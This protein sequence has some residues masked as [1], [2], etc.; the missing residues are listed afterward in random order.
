MA[1]TTVS[2]TSALQSALSAASPGDTIWLNPGA[3]ADWYQDGLDRGGW[4]VVRA[5]DPGERPIFHKISFEN[6]KRLH[7]IDI[8]V[9]VTGECNGVCYVG[10]CTDVKFENIWTHGD[11]SGSVLDV[12]D[13]VIA[14]WDTR[15][16][17]R[18]SFINSEFR[19]L[20][21]GIG[22]QGNVGARYL[23]NVFHEIRSDGI[24]GSGF[25]DLIIADN[26]FADFYPQGA[27]GTTGDHP[28]A[29]QIFLNYAHAGSSHILI[30]NNRIARGRGRQI[31]G[32]SCFQEDST[33]HVENIVIRRNILI[34]TSYNSIYVSGGINV[35]ITDNVVAPLPDEIGDIT[36]SG[37]SG[38]IVTD[39]LTPRVDLTG[40]TG[41]TI[42]GNVEGA[43]YEIS[44]RTAAQL[45]A[46]QTL[47]LQTMS[48]AKTSGR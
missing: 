4:I 13:A 19:R 15:R 40:S 21:N 6:V 36:V 16:N 29:V 24:N 8:V 11:L 2:T 48:T 28:D 7:L 41:V 39:N 37:C 20:Y 30:E 22:N 46:S 43:W 42:G 3:Y 35:T 25:I 18:L 23:G 10:D 31:Q 17:T 27:V 44:P 32:I 33:K 26:Y 9:D 5:V 38:V 45:S 1:N 12:I 47:S 14:P 34:G